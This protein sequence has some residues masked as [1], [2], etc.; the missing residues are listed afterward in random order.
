MNEASTRGIARAVEE[1]DQHADVESAL[2]RELVHLW[3]DLF[4]A[5]RMAHRDGWSMACEGIVGRIA[6][7]SRVMGRGTPW[8]AVPISLIVEGVWQAVHAAIGVE[9][10]PPDMAEVMALHEEDQRQAAG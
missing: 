1:A 2:E 6:S 3:Y 9:V 8:G 10:E 7:L 5:R 4:W